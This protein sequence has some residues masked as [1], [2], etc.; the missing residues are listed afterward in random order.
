MNFFNLF[1]L[2]NLKNKLE[3]FIVDIGYNL[4]LKEFLFIK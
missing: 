1:K 4:F 2:L 3:Y